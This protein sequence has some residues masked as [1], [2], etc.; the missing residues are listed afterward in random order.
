MCSTGGFYTKVA[1]YHGNRRSSG[2]PCVVTGAERGGCWLFHLL[3]A[4]S[5]G[6]P[7]PQQHLRVPGYS[8]HFVNQST[9]AT[10]CVAATMR[11]RPYGSTMVSVTCR[12]TPRCIHEQER[13][14]TCEQI[15]SLHYSKFVALWD[16]PYNCWCPI[17]HVLIVHFSR[18]SLFLHH[19][20]AVVLGESC[21]V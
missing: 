2:F 5:L 11:N 12:Q 13:L 19:D 10:G 15:R 18:C 17:I 4:S 3:R 7:R 9:T 14:S 1:Y 8:P 6:R 20:G 21:L 16:R